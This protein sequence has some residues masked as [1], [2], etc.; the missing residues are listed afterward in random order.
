MA[1]YS[2]K[3]RVVTVVSPPQ[4]LWA[5]I[6]IQSHRSRAGLITF[7]PAVLAP[8][9]RQ[10]NTWRPLPNT[11]CPSSD[12]RRIFVPS[13]PRHASILVGFVTAGGAVEIR[14]ENPLRGSDIISG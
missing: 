5:N 13:G 11:I 14:G 10:S 4:G 7:A 1:P 2:I 6:C 12:F 3:S 9:V 8:H